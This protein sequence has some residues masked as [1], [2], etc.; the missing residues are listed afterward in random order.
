MVTGDENIKEDAVFAAV[1]GGLAARVGGRL[2]FQAGSILFIPKHSCFRLEV[3]ELRIIWLL[4]SS[5]KWPDAHNGS[6]GASWPTVN[7][8]LI[9]LWSPPRRVFARFCVVDKTLRDADA[10]NGHK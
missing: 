1:A 8:P 3:F 6:F 9:P 4:N 7:R 5:L 2:M 10:T